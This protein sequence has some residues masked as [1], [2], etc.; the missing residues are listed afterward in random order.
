VSRLPD[1]EQQL[2]EAARAL[3][4]PRRRWWRIPALGGGIA[5][6][7][8][9]TA[10][11]A[12]QLLL[13]EGDPV[14]PAP[15]AQRVSIPAMA[16][17]TTRLL[18]VRAADPEGG[19][20]WGLALA[21]SADGRL[22]CAQVGRVQDG[23]LGVIGRDGTFDDDGRFHP[24]SA[25]SNQSGSCGGVG[26][27]RGELHLGGDGPPI[28]ASGYTGG[29]DGPAGGCRENVPDNTI[30][31]ATLRRLRDVPK[32]KDSSLRVV[33]YGLA[34]PDVVKIEYAGRVLK[35]DPRES[36]AYLFVLRPTGRPLTLKLTRSDGSVCESTFPL[37]IRPGSR[38][39]RL[40]P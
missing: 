37:R 11:G 27:R 29:F 9:A 30:P 4:R 1:L 12:M 28:P 22:F 39:P 3:E 18:S 17:G 26:P 32:C 34:G 38:L 23:R 40:C 13:P 21:R 2:L 10:I 36:G 5:L 20:P 7:L 6:A 19:P 24:L 25:N 14:P 16:P 15:R 8:T 35:P 31:P 33:K